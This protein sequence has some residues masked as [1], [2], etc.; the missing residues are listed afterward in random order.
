MA[1]FLK[2][3]KGILKQVAP[4]LG[5]AV[6]GPFGGMAAKI[7]TSTL[8]GE[9]S[10]DINVA[11]EAVANAKPEQLLLLKKADNDFKVQ[12]RELDIKE[13]SLGNQDRD[14]ARKRQIETKDKMPAV[15]ALAVLTGFFGILLAM[16]FVTIPDNALSPLNIML[17][18]LATLVT[19]IGAYYYGSSQ[20]LLGRTPPSSGSSRARKTSS[21]LLIRRLH[22]GCNTFRSRL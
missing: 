20:V 6:G 8:L 22:D 12:M 18:S 2:A 14:S 13:Q 17:G 16:I 1:D 3:A 10:D 9:E 11:M 15:I 19:Q 5:V 7:I 21:R 4:T